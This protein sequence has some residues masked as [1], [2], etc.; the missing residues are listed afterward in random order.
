MTALRRFLPLFRSSVLGAA[1]GAA[2]L[3]SA[4]LRADTIVAAGR[5]ATTTGRPLVARNVDLGG[6]SSTTVRRTGAAQH[7][8]SDTVDYV[9]TKGDVV[10]TQVPHTIGFAHA[11]TESLLPDGTL[12]MRESY[13]NDEGVLVLS[14]PLPLER[15]LHLTAAEAARPLNGLVRS[16]DPAYEKRNHASDPN[17]LPYVLPSALEIER[18]RRASQ[19][20]VA[21]KDMKP[22]PDPDKDAPEVLEAFE[23]SG[24][25]Y[26]LMR[27]MTER[28]STARRA[29]EEAVRLVE[30]F[31]WAGEAV[32][33]TVADTEEVWLVAVLP[34]RTAVAR[35]LADDEAVL[36]AE[37]QTLGTVDLLDEKNTI[38]SPLTRERARMLL[39]NIPEGTAR[40]VTF[41]WIDYAEP[42]TLQARLRSYARTRTFLKRIGGLSEE[43]VRDA[44]GMDY[45]R[46]VAPGTIRPQTKISPEAL[47]ALMRSSAPDLESSSGI[48]NAATARSSVF[49]LRTP[50]WTTREDVA[51]AHPAVIPYVATHPLAVQ[52]P[53]KILARSNETGAA[54]AK[55]DNT[56]FVETA[57]QSTFDFSFRDARSFQRH[58]AVLYAFDAAHGAVKPSENSDAPWLAS[59]FAAL[60]KLPDGLAEARFLA[61]KVSPAKGAHHLAES[62]AIARARARA[63][64]FEHYRTRATPS[65]TILADTLSTKDRTVRVNVLSTPD[66]DATKLVRKSLGL[67]S[68]IPLASGEPNHRRSEATALNRID[69]NGDGRLDAVI[70]FPIAGALEGALPGRYTPLY[71][72]GRTTDKKPFIGFDSVFVKKP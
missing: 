44:T 52:L 58:A 20:F 39:A 18:M 6:T 19:E 13:L 7:K 62:D 9:K 37:V 35:R 43:A 2:L 15:T 28:G 61:D 21:R 23:S 8:W 4:P 17:R 64:L 65:V 22:L 16:P 27:L 57:V 1:L 54:S 25:V 67:G 36:A 26:G 71:V 12:L 68:A 63:V 33:L 72:T 53:V 46:F 3:S 5:L 69:V 48:A 70:T 34:G 32:Q 51:S 59:E 31:G 29:V 66:F 11:R 50:A 38:V 40:T 45:R 41:D 60:E 55:G 10:L 30:R 49:D 14:M 56:P 24:I 47:R 42:P